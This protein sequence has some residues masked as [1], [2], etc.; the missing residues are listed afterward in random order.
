MKRGREGGKVEWRDGGKEIQIHIHTLTH[1]QKNV[2]ILIASN[3]L[4][5]FQPNP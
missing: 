2:S 5:M 4:F 1:T 3:I